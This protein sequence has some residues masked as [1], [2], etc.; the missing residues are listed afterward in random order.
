MKITRTRYVVLAD[1]GTRIFCGT[2]SLNRFRDL[3]E[4]DKF[5]YKSAKTENKI[6]SYVEND[7][8]AM[9]LINEHNWDY[10]AVKTEE[11]IDFYV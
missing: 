5:E 3:T 9:Q 4:I 1:H 6:L 8:Y 7:K 2:N 10:K 11:E